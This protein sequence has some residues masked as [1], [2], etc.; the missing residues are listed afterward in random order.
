MLADL[1]GATNAAAIEASGHLSFHS[2]G[3]TGRS[4]DSPQ[5]AVADAM[6]DDFDINA[7]AKS[8]AFFFHLGDVIYGPQ[9]DQSYRREFYEPYVHYPG[10]II[11]IAGNH[12][13]EV[14]PKTDPT[15]LRAFRANFCATKQVVP[16]IAGTIF[17][18]TMTQ[19]GVYWMLRAP[20]VDI[21]GLYSNVAENPGFICGRVPGMAQKKWLAARLKELATERKKGSRRA[22]VMATH[23]PPF[24]SGGHSP[25]TDMLND[26]DEVTKNAGVWPDMF[27][28]GHAH[29]YQRYTR[30]VSAGDK[31][32]EI[33]YLVA[34][35]GGI[36]AQ[37]IKDADRGKT[38][39]HTF[40]KSRKG[41]GYLTITASRDRLRAAFT[42]VD[43]DTQKAKEFDD[44][45][46]DLAK[47]KLT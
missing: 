39:D 20:F 2:T 19:P 8:P 32:L 15:T 31:T 3:D 40:E 12:D 9:K 28:S 23:H 18:E 47:G 46:V 34:G 6:A 14:F 7:P 4:A 41:F 38:G 29:S 30:F 25:S 26:L 24:T 17:R 21:I 35:T 11:A 27:L 36:S 45:E 22:L 16:K 33:P 44:V 37:A 10:K 43:P 42:G 5:G 1:I 13:G